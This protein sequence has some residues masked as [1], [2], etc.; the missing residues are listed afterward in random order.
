MFD[1]R[2]LIPFSFAMGFAGF[3]FELLGLIFCKH[4]FLGRASEGSFTTDSS[5]Y[6]KHELRMR[7]MEKLYQA[8]DLRPVVET[9]MM[10]WVLRALGAEIGNDCEIS[11]G[12]YE[13]DLLKM[14][15]F[16]MVE[17]RPTSC[18]LKCFLLVRKC[19]IG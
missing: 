12:Q 4:L 16:C 14:G 6:I 17:C 19:L 11:N 18:K 8:G 10:P 1:V 13:P 5:D 15:D 9:R 2:Y 3:W 7:L